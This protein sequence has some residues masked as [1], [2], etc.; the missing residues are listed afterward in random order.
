MTTKDD[1]KEKVLT[2]AKSEDV[3]F[4]KLQFSDMFGIVKSVTIPVEQLEESME[5][6]TWFDDSSIEG[7]A[8]ICESD[9]YLMPDPS[10]FAVLPWTLPAVL[11][12]VLRT[13][14]SRTCR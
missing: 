7:F 10:T 14:Q 4:I 1:L 9:M 3:K 6:G 11:W 2:E 12:E 5:K 13:S 8:R